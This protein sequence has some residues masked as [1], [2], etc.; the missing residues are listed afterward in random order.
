MD[1]S[2][3]VLTLAFCL[4]VHP[5]IHLYHYYSCNYRHSGRSVSLQ[6]HKH[7]V[8]SSDSYPFVMMLMQYQ[9]NSTNNMHYL[10]SV[11]YD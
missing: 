5:R 7:M 8:P 1:I 4:T 11:Y 9:Y 2:Q 6:Q 10:V 3:S